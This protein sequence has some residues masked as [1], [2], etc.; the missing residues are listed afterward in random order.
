MQLNTKQNKLISNNF[1]GNIVIKNLN[2]S[3]NKQTPILSNINLTIKSSHKILVTG[4]SGSG[5]STLFKILKGY[6]KDYEGSITIGNK[7]LK[8]YFFKN[9]I[10]VSGKFSSF[11]IY[12]VLS[13]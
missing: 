13:T 2:F 6:Y 9:I 12:L 10:Y 4:N 1:N 11:S 3:Y 8:K 5:K 7:N